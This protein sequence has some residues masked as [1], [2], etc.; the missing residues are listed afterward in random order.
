M[1]KAQIS[2][3]ILIGIVLL[4]IFGALFIVVNNVFLNQNEQ[5]TPQSFVQDCLQIAARQGLEELGR[6]SSVPK[7][8]DPLEIRQPENSDYCISLSTQDQMITLETIE[9][10]QE[11]LAPL[12][13]SKLVSCVNGFEPLKELGYSP[14]IISEPDSR[15]TFTPK[16]VVVES[17]FEIEFLKASERE[18]VDDLFVSIPSKYKII[19]ESAKDSASQYAKT[20][21]FPAESLNDAGQTVLMTP[22][23]QGT[24]ILPIDGSSGIQQPL[25]YTFSYR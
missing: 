20:K 24:L 4:M 2:A 16:E 1:K 3:F 18:M 9:Q 8:M 22:E 19:H 12:I 10:I 23:P 14:T 7:T 6:F 21:E 5:V 25:H 13:D 15:V 17:R 11:Q